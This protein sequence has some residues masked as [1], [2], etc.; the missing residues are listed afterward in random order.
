M[1]LI[2]AL[3][4]VNTA[5]HWQLLVALALSL[6]LLVID[7]Q[8]QLISQ[9]RWMLNT[10]VQPIEQLARIPEGWFVQG[11]RLLNEPANLRA[12]I[13]RLK[14]QLLLADY[15]KQQTSLIV[16]ENERLK[17][18]LGVSS[19]VSHSK[20]LV[21]K[22]VDYNPN[23]FKQTVKVN[24]GLNEGVQLGLPV[25]DANG[26]MGQIIACALGES[27]VLLITDSDMQ[28]PIRV[29]RT[30]AR[31]I[32]QGTGIDNELRVKFLPLVANIQTGDLIETSG[33]DG[34]FPAGLPVA[35][36]IS[37]ENPA[38]AIFWNVVAQP[39][40]QLNTSREVLIV[41]NSS[42]LE[43]RSDNP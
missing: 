6:S 35:Q 30:G 13:D 21:A 36:V 41:N 39:I 34:R 4:K 26:M 20:L 23:L 5:D 42:V 31:A 12:E 18:L 43:K 14:N 28:V 11:D 15:E 8:T 2:S 33:I 1:M 19:K 17:M 40:A 25:M 32:L 9:T 24:K 38:G 3:N 7:E 37:A 29:Q 16:A 10:L 22:V 27:H